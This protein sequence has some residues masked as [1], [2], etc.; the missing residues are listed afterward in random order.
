VRRFS[1]N[2]YLLYDIKYFCTGHC[3]T[4]GLCVKRDFSIVFYFKLDY[5]VF[6]INLIL[7]AIMS[8]PTTALSGTL[9]NLK[10]RIS[11]LY[12]DERQFKDDSGK[13]VKYDRLVLEL[14]IKG[15]VFTIEFKPEKK[16]KAILMLAD[17]LTQPVT[18]AQ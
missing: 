9:D 17:D 6:V 3:A 5:V 13:V 1:F 2:L 8:L 14:L 10:S 16:D 11:R 18:F 12:F 4:L 7:E 15:E